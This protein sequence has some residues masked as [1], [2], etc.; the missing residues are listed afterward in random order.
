MRPRANPMIYDGACALGD[1]RIDQRYHEN[2]LDQMLG[3]KR[4]RT[5]GDLLWYP[6]KVVFE[7]FQAKKIRTVEDICI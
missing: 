2:Y 7:K 1:T 6:K 3:M 5:G 4:I